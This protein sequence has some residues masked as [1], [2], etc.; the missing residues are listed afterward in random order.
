MMKLVLSFERGEC[1][2]LQI[3]NDRD[4]TWH[5]SLP[6]SFHR[7]I[8]LEFRDD[9]KTHNDWNASHT[10]CESTCLNFL[11]NKQLNSNLHVPFLMH[12]IMLRMHLY[13]I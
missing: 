8:A 1:V 11:P 12:G 3:S 5:V 7:E 4:M 13:A 10:V 6:F 9:C 2:N